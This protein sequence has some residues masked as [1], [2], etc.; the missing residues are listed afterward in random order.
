MITVKLNDILNSEETLKKLMDVSMKGKVAYKLARIAREVDKESQLFSDERN[1]LIEKYAERDEEGNYKP[2]EDGQI[3]IDTKNL[4]KVGQFSNEL[5]E[6]LETE[7][8]VNV[9][10]LSLDDLDETGLTPKDFNKLMA[11]IEE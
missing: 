1:K 5:S 11:F 3:Y 7:I 4:E 9:E 2:N 8:E 10:K 6:L